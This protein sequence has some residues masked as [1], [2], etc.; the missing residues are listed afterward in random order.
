MR[1]VSS[2]DELGEAWRRRHWPLCLAVLDLVFEHLLRVG[3]DGWNEVLIWLEK[4]LIQQVDDDAVA[5]GR[6][7]LRQMQRRVARV[8]LIHRQV[9]HLSLKRDTIYALKIFFP[10]TTTL[11]LLRELQIDKFTYSSH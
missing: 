10:K 7:D 1:V 2:L 3:T 5:I 9:H 8:L 11:S 6:D 4:V